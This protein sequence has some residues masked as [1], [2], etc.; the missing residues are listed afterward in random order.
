[1]EHWNFKP[2]TRWFQLQRLEGLIPTPGSSKLF[3]SCWHTVPGVHGTKWY[4]LVTSKPRL[5][6]LLY[7]EK[8]R[9]KVQLPFVMKSCYC[10]IWYDY[11]SQYK[12]KV[13]R[14]IIQWKNFGI[15]LH[16][17]MNSFKLISLNAHKKLEYLMR[18][19]LGHLYVLSKTIWVL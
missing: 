16:K 1:M 6:T 15:D 2:Y 8:Q 17:M 3:G 13:G 9:N 12:T 14:Y 19:V 5:S 18:E 10:K 11:I 7:M 4:S